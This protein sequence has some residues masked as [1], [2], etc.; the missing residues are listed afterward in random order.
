MDISEDS[1][2]EEKKKDTDVTMRGENTDLLP[3]VERQNV[4]VVFGCQPSDGVTLDTQMIHDAA[5]AM[6]HRFDRKTF[7]LEIPAVFEQLKGQDVNFEMITTNT[8]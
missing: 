2:A 1:E 5:H 7:I 4:I 8:L 3:P 6:E